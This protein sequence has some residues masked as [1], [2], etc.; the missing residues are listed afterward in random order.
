ME[1]EEYFKKFKENLLEQMKD[2]YMDGVHQGSIT[3]SAIIFSVMRK[4]GLEEHN[5][6]FDMLKDI[7]KTHGCEDLATYAENLET[8]KTKATKDNLLC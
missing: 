5:I 3:T 4:A 7:A 6:L 8:E 2:V 1:N